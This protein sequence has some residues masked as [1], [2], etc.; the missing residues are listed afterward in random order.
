MYDNAAI[1]TNNKVRTSIVFITHH[2]PLKTRGHLTH[3]GLQPRFVCKSTKF[4]ADFPQCSKM[5]QPSIVK[6]KK[7]HQAFD[8]LCFLAGPAL[9]D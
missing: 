2:P 5:N 1:T 3:R 6:K 8:D 7:F 9:A 4:R